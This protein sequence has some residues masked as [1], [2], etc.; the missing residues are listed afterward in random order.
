MKMQEM[1]SEEA[2]IRAEIILDALHDA[3]EAYE[4]YKEVSKDE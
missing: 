3:E 2:V 4:E 1:T